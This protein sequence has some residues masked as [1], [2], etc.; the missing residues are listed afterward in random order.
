VAQVEIV[1]TDLLA[2][3]SVGLND[4]G[5]CFQVLLVDLDDQVL[6]C[7][8]EQVVVVLEFSCEVLELLA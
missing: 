7:D 8:V 3:E 1:L 4:I 2:I 5:T 6:L